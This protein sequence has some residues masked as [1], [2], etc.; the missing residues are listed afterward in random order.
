[1]KKF[2]LIELL[3][4]IAIIAIL[5][6]ML[7]PALNSARDKAKSISCVSNL[8]QLGQINNSYLHDSDGFVFPHLYYK[9]SGATTKLFYWPKFLVQHKYATSYLDP[10]PGN[11]RVYADFGVASTRDMPIGIF[12]C[13]SDPFWEPHPNTGDK[14]DPDTGYSWGGSTYGVN[15]NI[16]NR[17]WDVPSHA[18]YKWLKISR[19]KSPSLLFYI[20]DAYGA[21]AQIREPGQNWIYQPKFRHNNS[22]N[23]LYLD[24]HIGNLKKGTMPTALKPNWE[25]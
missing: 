18:E 11:G 20:T 5:A 8:K 3:V 15:W 2:T 16:S 23:M 4:V 14:T 24:G 7:L 25:N 10:R 1:M 19:A 6:S 9:T 22:T 12:R 21:N 13:P 17:N